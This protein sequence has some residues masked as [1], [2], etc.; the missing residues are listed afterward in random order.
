MLWR[1]APDNRRLTLDH[2]ARANP[3]RLNY[4]DFR[5]HT[6]DFGIREDHDR[7]FVD[8]VVYPDV[9]QSIEARGVEVK[10]GRYVVPHL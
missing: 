6:R 2:L 1:W 7:D 9:M 5:R 8:Q 10:W 3:I 4:G